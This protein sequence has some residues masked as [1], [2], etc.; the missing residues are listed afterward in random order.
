MTIPWSYGETYVYRRPWTR[1][2]SPRVGEVRG[3]G[4]RFKVEDYSTT[5][6]LI[7]ET[8]TGGSLTVVSH[9]NYSTCRT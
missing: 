3:E 9:Y 7:E 5:S 6:D 4:L 2:L 8:S 1:R